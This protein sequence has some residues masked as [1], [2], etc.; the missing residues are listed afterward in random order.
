MLKGA[1][2]HVERLQHQ[3]LHQVGE[4]LAGY[5]RQYL[6]N[7]RVIAASVSKL[8]P[9]DKVNSYGC[10]V[11]GTLTVQYLDKRRQLFSNNV[12]L[13]PVNG[14]ACCVAE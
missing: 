1:V 6:L 2:R 11:C 3:F 12:T 7:D 13:K 14:C 10:R 8:G 4:W 5:V 9:R